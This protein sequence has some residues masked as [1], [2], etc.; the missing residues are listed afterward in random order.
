MCQ[1]RSVTHPSTRLFSFP[2][3]RCSFIVRCQQSSAQG[4]FVPGWARGRNTQCLESSAPGMCLQSSVWCPAA[5]GSLHCPWLTSRAVTLAVTIPLSSACDLRTQIN[6]H[7][8]SLGGYKRPLNTGRGAFPL[9]R[10]WRWVKVC[11]STFPLAE[12]SVCGHCSQTDT[13]AV[14]S[15][16]Q[17]R[18]FVLVTCGLNQTCHL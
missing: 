4:V 2:P 15:D 16:L 9:G 18:S 3:Q 7:S 10:L 6:G 5:L 13:P 12:D 1:S 11:R 14:C 8:V 17:A